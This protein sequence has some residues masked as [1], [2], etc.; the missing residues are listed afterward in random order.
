MVFDTL[1][2]FNNPKGEGFKIPGQ[3]RRPARYIYFQGF[4]EKR[5]RIICGD[6]LFIPEYPDV[7]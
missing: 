7:D 5:L 6:S 3:V 2:L 4:R 1:P